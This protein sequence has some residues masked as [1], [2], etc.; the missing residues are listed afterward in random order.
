M[1]PS[2]VAA[3]DVITGRFVDAQR[4]INWRIFFSLS[5]SPCCVAIRNYKLIGLLEIA[6]C[7]GERKKTKKWP[8]RTGQLVGR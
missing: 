5:F 3:A 1:T 2:T 6:I 7:I 4:R 8:S